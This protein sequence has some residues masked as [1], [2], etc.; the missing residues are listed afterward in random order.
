MLTTKTHIQSLL[1]LVL[2]IIILLT[3]ASFGISQTKE[4]EEPLYLIPEPR[5]A[6]RKNWLFSFDSSMAITIGTGCNEVDREHLDS[7]S[8]YLGVKGR[9]ALPVIDEI[10]AQ[11][12]RG[13]LFGNPASSEHVY[14]ILN[15]YQLVFSKEMGQEGYFLVVDTTR[16]VI[17]GKTPRAR[18]YGLQTLYQLLKQ[19]RGTPVLP[20]L[21][22][23]DW[24][25]FGFR[26]I[27]DDISR[28]QVSTLN[29]FKHI[30]K[31][32]AG[33]KMNVYLLYLEDMVQFSSHPEIGKGR[34]ALSPEEIKSIVQYATKNYVEV[35][36]IFETLSHQENLFLIPQFSNLE[37]FPGS[38]TFNLASPDIYILLE[39]LVGEIAGLFPSPYFHIGGDDGSE[40]GIFK[41]RKLMSEVGMGRLMASHYNSI[42]RILEKYKKRLIMYG[43]TLLENPEIIS[44]LKK[45]VVVVDEQSQWNSAEYPSLDFF[46]KAAF[47]HIVCP[48][49]YNVHTIFPDYEKA[50]NNISGFLQAGYKRNALGE[51]TSSWNDCGGE[52]LREMNWFGY[53]FSSVA[54]SGGVVNPNTFLRN[55]L[56]QFYGL[57]TTMFQEAFVGLWR[58]NQPIRFARINALECWS[59]P[60]A[61]PYAP[62]EIQK[63][64]EIEELGNWLVQ[65]FKSVRNLMNQNQ[66]SVD[67]LIF[68]G[69]KAKWL[70]KKI[71]SASQVMEIEQQLVKKTASSAPL[72]KEA[73]KLLTELREEI[74]ALKD[75]Y[76][77]LWHRTNK[78]EGLEFNL[79]RFDTQIRYLDEKIAEI[80]AHVF[81]RSPLLPGDWI[82]TQNMREQKIKLE[83]PDSACFR[84][85]FT[86]KGG[87][88]EASLQVRCFSYGKV[89]MN[90]EYIGEVHSRNPLSPLVLERTVLV[91][92]VPV[93][94]F[95]QGENV[96]AIEAVFFDPSREGTLP[97][98]HACLTLKMVDGSQ[99]DIASDV[100][101]AANVNS[102]EGWQK[103]GF[104]VNWKPAV[105]MGKKP[106]NLLLE[107]LRPDV[108]EP[109][110][111][112]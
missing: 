61:E 98:L 18:F 2:G 24:P 25:L 73:D 35:I 47:P 32:L 3:D 28:G 14:D 111:S 49:I 46:Q 89:Y 94:I 102:Q 78:T 19:F 55:F 43:G 85:T 93:K 87:V 91:K 27:S 36:P 6:I 97:G 13:I 45:N 80:N 63:A 70:G 41:S 68:A 4:E 31:T 107:Q 40:V 11:T 77:N 38:S 62:E 5:F 23:Q 65:Q 84:K 92:P 8:K 12:K 10:A 53:A 86:V 20:G 9:S 34:G 88:K 108:R 110:P 96:L 57:S 30:I 16:I 64:K 104:A 39:K 95:L 22:I 66:A 74:I 82:W 69:S 15:K 109:V 71:R 1:Y 52:V 54:W 99:V 90:G 60:F 105:S 112:Q 76:A 7:L 58:V 72:Q 50:I 21:V 103:T 106:V 83:I 17:A 51:I 26:G 67:Y 29:D 33:F 56:A 100:T 79:K 75:M 48:T 44:L 81:Q 42:Y 101:W 37:E 59:H